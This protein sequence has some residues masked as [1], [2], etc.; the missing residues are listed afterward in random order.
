MKIRLMGPF[1]LLA[2][3]LLPV[4]SARAVEGEPFAMSP[5][6]G[7]RGTRVGISGV[8]KNQAGQAGSTVGYFLQNQ[9]GDSV[10]LEDEL[11]VAGNGNWSGRFRI[12]TSDIAGRGVTPGDYILRADCDFADDTS[13]VLYANHTFTITPGFASGCD[14]SCN[15]DST[16]DCGGDPACGGNSSTAPASGGG[17]GPAAQAAAAKAAAAQN[18]TKPGSAS[19]TNS[20]PAPGGVSSPEVPGTPVP[21]DAGAS[22]SVSAGTAI[23]SPG[24]DTTSRKRNFIKP[25]SAGVAALVILLLTT[26]LIRKARSRPSA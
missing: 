5:S 25:V 26:L 10:L 6:S 3:L 13:G 8:C 7:P 16:V 15:G 9:S 20:P 2:A 19:R 21:G 12:P 17:F 18:S 14:E 23:A 24:P 11:Q 4:V 22:P 1:A